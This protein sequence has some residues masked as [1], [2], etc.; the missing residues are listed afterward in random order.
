MKKKN[1]VHDLPQER[2][3]SSKIPP[4]V[5]SDPRQNISAVAFCTGLTKRVGMFM[6]FVTLPLH[7]FGN[8]S[9]NLPSKSSGDFW[10]TP[11]IGFRFD[12]NTSATHHNPIICTS[13]K[14]NARQRPAK[15]L[16]FNRKI[17]GGKFRARILNQ[18]QPKR[19]EIR[20]RRQISQN[21]LEI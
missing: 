2:K 7:H 1:T 16:Q 21:L 9:V 20:R 8:S 6:N 11:L 5:S 12:L 15:E 14:Q 18:L 17:F 13:K 3:G 4:K 10:K 19:K